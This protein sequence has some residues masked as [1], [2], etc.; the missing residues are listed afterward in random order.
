M[1]LFLSDVNILTDMR[2]FVSPDHIGSHVPIFAAQAVSEL[3]GVDSTEIVKHDEVYYMKDIMI[4]VSATSPLSEV[5]T[6]MLR[7]GRKHVVQ[8]RTGS[9]RT[10]DRS[11]G[12]TQWQ[13]W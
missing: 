5:S 3:R 4:R 10:V 6:T 11:C 8:D 12:Y 7:I 1:P 13:P 9:S 2:H